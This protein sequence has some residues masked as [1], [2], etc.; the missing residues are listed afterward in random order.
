[1]P[2]IERQYDQYSKPVAIAYIGKKKAKKDTLCRSG[3][4]WDGHGDIQCVDPR[5]ASVLLKHKAVFIKAED[6][7]EF[8]KNM[9]QSLKEDLERE[10]NETTTLTNESSIEPEIVNEL[11]EEEFKK[12]ES[13]QNVI[14]ALDTENEDHFGKNGTPKIEAIRARMDGLEV[15]V[16][17]VKAA[18]KD[19]NPDG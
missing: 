2:V 15:S 19:L 4:V 3:V 16:E 11:S 14:L 17:D 12:M 10:A 9:E 7:E 13:I 5:A 6:L 8:K 18:Y 1:M